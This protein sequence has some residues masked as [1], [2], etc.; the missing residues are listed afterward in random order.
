MK[1]KIKCETENKAFRIS[2]T[3]ENI[4]NAFSN[5]FKS[6]VR[7]NLIFHKIVL[8]NFTKNAKKRISNKKINASQIAEVHFPPVFN[9][10]DTEDQKIL[11]EISLSSLEMERKNRTGSDSFIQE[12][13]FINT[14]LR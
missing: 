1:N 11:S 9:A 8:S 13:G 2:K 10:A 7:I 14:E 12:I 5:L 6:K 4:H 3:L